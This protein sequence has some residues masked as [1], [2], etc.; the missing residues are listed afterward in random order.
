MS[1]TIRVEPSGSPAATGER[2]AGR[3]SGASSGNPSGLAT[4][5]ALA[6]ALIVLAYVF[7]LP[8]VIMGSYSLRPFSGLAQAGP[9][10]TL[11]NYGKFFGDLFYWGIVADTLLLGAIVVAISAVI[12]YPPAYF[13]AR[14]TS[15]WRSLLVFIVISPLLISV[16][17]RNLGWIPLLGR[18]GLVNTVI[19]GL[20][21]SSEPLALLNNFTG[22][23]IGLVHALVPFMILSLMIAIRRI[24]VDLE[25]AATGLGAGPFERFRLIVLPLSKSGL[26]AG[27]LIVFT[28]SISAF[29]TVAMMGGKRVLLMATYAEQQVRSGLNYP[30]GATIAMVLLALTAL[31]SLSALRLL[32]ERR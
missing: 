18:N 13:L 17:I 7:A 29:T 5:L 1:M 21:L 31:F 23:V 14:T 12:A 27:C 22:V 4:A 6:P 16:I 15:R 3:A 19:L 2:R 8:I 30:V 20:G 24:G 25:E 10:W 28:L 9:G 11:A 32:R 26:L